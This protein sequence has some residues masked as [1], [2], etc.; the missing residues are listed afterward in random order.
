MG[1]GMV[2]HQTALWVLLIACSA[3]GVCMRAIAIRRTAEEC[4]ASRV[5]RF[6]AAALIGVGLGLSVAAPGSG[7]DSAARGMSAG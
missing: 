2:V 4:L 5:E 3:V 6:V 7:A 1:S